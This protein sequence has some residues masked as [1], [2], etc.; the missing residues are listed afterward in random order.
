VPQGFAQYLYETLV[1]LH[2]QGSLTIVE[3]EC[4]DRLPP[5]FIFNTS[6]GRPEWQA[7]NALILGVEEDIDN[8][9]TKVQFGPPI[10]LGLDTKEEL[11]RANLGRLPSFKL[12]Q[13]NTGMADMGGNVIQGHS[14]S[15]SS[16]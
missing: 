16:S 3:Q 10:S 2:Y 14:Q 13:R 15:A 11:F 8:G 7:M 9:T 1:P 12:D 6:D 5:G 4:S